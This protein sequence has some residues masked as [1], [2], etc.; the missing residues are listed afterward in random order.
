MARMASQSQAEVV[1]QFRAEPAA[2]LAVLQ[3][4]VPAGAAPFALV[5]R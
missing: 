4:L 2:L 1:A 3:P 5:L